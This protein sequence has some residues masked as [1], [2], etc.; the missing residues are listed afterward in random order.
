V[1][2]ICGV[3]IAFTESYPVI[4]GKKSHEHSVNLARPPAK[5]QIGQIKL[6]NVTSL[7]NM[8]CSL[9]ND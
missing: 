1:K 7:A 9:L 4:Y 3:D 6:L 2:G 5:I 8:I